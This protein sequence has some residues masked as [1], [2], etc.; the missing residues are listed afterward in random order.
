[1]PI[2]SFST[3]EPAT[4]VSFAFCGVDDP[5]EVLDESVEP[6][7][8]ELL[9]VDLQLRSEATALDFQL[10]VGDAVRLQS[11]GSVE[12]V[13]HGDTLVGD[14]H[15]RRV[16][17]EQRDR[18][19]ADAAESG[20]QCQ[21]VVETA[22]EQRHAGGHEEREEREQSGGELG[23]V[24]P[25]SAVVVAALDGDVLRR[26][27]ESALAADDG[28]DDQEHHADRAGSDACD[29]QPRERARRLSEQERGEERERRTDDCAPE[30]WGGETSV[31]VVDTRGDGC[32]TERG[33]DPGS[34]E[35]DEPGNGCT[36][37]GG[38]ERRE[39]DEHEREV[40]AGGD[41]EEGLAAGHD[42]RYRAPSQK[43]TARL[44]E[45]GTVVHEDGVRNPPPQH[46]TMETDTP[47]V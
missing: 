23:A 32:S 16:V 30:E 8:V 35:T 21:S 20:E 17:V 14:S 1:V 18:R 6:L 45:R 19:G 36:G 26:C 28:S 42:C 4:P 34:E 38:Q 41:R 46:D 11:V 47:R 27:G 29:G 7:F 31:E 13:V 15:L 9:A 2:V 5:V 43:A 24:L 10:V 39:R 33:D 22:V 44:S 40:D 3:P 37:R 25:A 12:E